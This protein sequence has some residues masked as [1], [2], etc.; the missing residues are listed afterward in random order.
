MPQTTGEKKHTLMSTGQ[1]KHAM[2]RRT[3]PCFLVMRSILLGA[4][5]F[6]G[7]ISLHGQFSSDALSIDQKGNV[8]FSGAVGINR[9]PIANQ[10]LVITPK[11]GNMPFNVTSPEGKVNWL[12]V[13]SDGKVIMKGGNVGIGTTEPTAKLDVIGNAK[14]SA[15]VGIGKI[16][17]AKLALDVQ[18]DAQFNGKFDVSRDLAVKG[19]TTLNGPVDIANLAV[20]ASTT[21]SGPVAIGTKDRI[22]SLDVNGNAALFGKDSARLFLR[23]FDGSGLSLRYAI[24]NNNYKIGFTD[25]D[26]TPA[27]WLFWTDSSGNTFIRGNLTLDGQLKVKIGGAYKTLQTEPLGN[28]GLH[29]DKRLKTDIR[30]IS[31]AS[32]K[33]RQLRG[34]TYRWSQEGLDYFTRDIPQT[35]SAGPDAT[36]EKN[37][38]AQQAERERRYKELAGTH[39]GVIAQDVEAVLPEAVTADEQGY[40][41]VKY[42]YLIA[43]LIEA[44]KEQEESV[45]QQAQ[46]V[47]RQQTEI[48]RLTVANQAAQQQLSEFAEMKTK[49]SRL[50]AGLTRLMA[51]DSSGGGRADRLALNASQ[52][53]SP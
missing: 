14:F 27:A 36:A 51:A 2:L 44:L 40:K 17:D 1:S 15:G 52:A 35:I 45:Q 25:A 23:A 22:A 47:A 21:L 6:L 5:L 8:R 41:S 29:S 12:S 11:E 28:A 9:D 18:G 43:L 39:V 3:F 33:V 31:S 20:K 10:H 46:I 49:L 53:D 48:Q 4:F 16:P 34:I 26:P 7:D 38:E 42:H 50:E 19:S 32:E 13:F 30:L 24:E 37:Q